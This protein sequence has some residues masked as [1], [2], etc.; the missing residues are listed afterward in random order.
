VVVFFSMPRR[1]VVILFSAFTPDVV[2]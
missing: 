2:S 1:D